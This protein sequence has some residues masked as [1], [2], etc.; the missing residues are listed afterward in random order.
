MHQ[1]VDGV[2]ILRL[3]PDLVPEIFHDCHAVSLGHAVPPVLM[4]CVA[5]GTSGVRSD[6]RRIWRGVFLLR[7]G[8]A[9]DGCDRKTHAWRHEQE[10]PPIVQPTRPGKDMLIW[11]CGAL[12]RIAMPS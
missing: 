9:E 3:L 5:R 10:M 7:S 8:A 2:G 11:Y 4:P 1:A 12:I 6:L